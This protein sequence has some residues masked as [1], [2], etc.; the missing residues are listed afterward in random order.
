MNFSESQVATL[1]EEQTLLGNALKAV[2]V[3]A[4]VKKPAT[5]PREDDVPPP[6]EPGFSFF[7]GFRARMVCRLAKLSFFHGVCFTTASDEVNKGKMVAEDLR[8]VMNDKDAEK[9][10]HTPPGPVFILD[11]NPYYSL[12]GAGGK[13]AGGKRD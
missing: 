9:Q 2:E 3:F 5:S 4:G 13:G 11:L 12:L 7:V 8:N 6:Y 10:A 1:K